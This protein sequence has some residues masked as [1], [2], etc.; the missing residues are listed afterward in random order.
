MEMDVASCLKAF[1]SSLGSYAGDDPLDVWLKFVDYLDGTLAPGGDGISTVLDRLLQTFLGAERY[2]EDIRFVRLC[3]RCAAYCSEPEAFFQYILS[4]GTGTRTATLYLAWAQHLERQHRKEEADAVYRKALE[5]RAQPAGDLAREYR[6]FQ[7]R[8][9]SRQTPSPGAGCAERPDEGQPRPGGFVRAPSQPELQADDYFSVRTVSR[10]EVRSEPRGEC[11]SVSMYSKDVLEWQGSQLC[12][13]EVRATAYLQKRR[14]N[15]EKREAEE[16]LRLER[17][18]EEDREAVVSL[19]RQLDLMGRMLELPLPVEESPA[20]DDPD[21]D[22]YRGAASR[23][24]LPAT[25]RDSSWAHVTPSRVPPSPTVNTREALDVIMGMF[26]APTLSGA[27]FGDPSAAFVG[28]D[29]PSPDRCGPLFPLPE[30]D[31]REPQEG[32]SPA[33]LAS[34]A[35]FTIYQD[36]VSALTGRTGGAAAV[37]ADGLGETAAPSLLESAMDFAPPTSCATTPFAQRAASH[38]VASGTCGDDGD[39]NTFVRRLQKLSPILEQSPPDEKLSSEGPPTLA[40]ATLS[41][42]E[43][44]P[45]PVAPE[46]V[47]R[48]GPR[49]AV[50]SDPWSEGLVSR[51]LSE[52]SPPL[53]SHPQYVSW[54]RGLPDIAPKTTVSMGRAHLRVERVLGRGAFATVYQASDPTGSDKLV[55]KV[56]KPANPWEFYINVQLDRRL[57]PSARQLFGRILSAHV[58]TDGSVLVAELHGYGTLLNAVNLYK[59]LG[60]KVMPQPLVMYFTVCMLRMLEELHA[61]RLIHA[62]VKPDNFVLG[63]RFVENDDFESENLEHGL[64][65]VDFGQSVDMELFPEGA[66]FTAKCLTSGFQCPQMLAGKPWSYQTDM[67]GVAATAHVLLFGT[68]MQPTEE[69]GVWMPRASFRRN[70]HADTWRHFFLTL[71]NVTAC[72]PA[73]ETLADLRRRLSDVLRRDYAAKMASLKSRLLVLLLESAKV[74]RR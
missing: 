36:D 62:D 52:M 14:L 50:P 45:G 54:G 63:Q 39:E 11:L 6:H 37:D 66:A 28:G 68:Y 29:P 4:K 38:A 20:P 61:A 17:S 13:E 19:R 31:R 18:V 15:R 73:P 48:N 72:R 24:S 21:P 56:Q 58:F 34:A 5:N 23:E 51:L 71:L 59:N 3:V 12:F 53:G 60:D 30:P 7:A 32:A 40:S 27:A 69:D 57:G 1:E 65:L 16:R 10:S 25:S 9:E 64:V 55:L 33:G 70:P 35:P 74:T 22:A 67:F 47:G 43:R 42:G 26:Q 2:A 41:F 44:T 46:E 8:S 49:E